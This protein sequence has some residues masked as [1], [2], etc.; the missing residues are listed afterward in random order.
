MSDL[1]G[2]VISAL[3]WRALSKL[4]AQLVSW[5]S[6]ILVMRQLLPDDYGLMAMGMVV[7][8]VSTL[9]AEMGMGATVVQAK[10]V[11]P[12]LLG[13]VAGLCI[14]SMTGLYLL[15]VL[16]SPLLQYLLSEP[17]LPGLL[18]IVALQLPLSALGVVPAATSERAMQYK[19]LS[20]IDLLAYSSAAL[21]TLL[22]AWAGWGVWALVCSQLSATGLRVLMLL[23]RFGWVRPKFDFRNHRGV[24]AFGGTL[25]IT[26]VIWSLS[27]QA[28]ILVGGKMVGAGA[29][30]I[31]TVAA[32]LANM[33]LQ[34]ISGIANQV[35][36]AALSRLQEKEENL[37]LAVMR[38][39]GNMAAVGAPLIWGIGAA[40]STLVPVL[41]GDKWIQAILPM[42]LICV[43]G[44]LRMVAS[45]LSSASIA[46]GTV[47]VDLRN[48][49]T[50]A[51]MMTPSFIVGAYF[52]GSTGIAL[53]W[54][55]VYPVVLVINTR[56]VCRAL[57]MSPWSI[58][59]AVKAPALAAL[60]SSGSV[61]LVARLAAVWPPA[62]VLAC[63]VLAGAAV[64]FALMSIW[65]PGF[66][67]D[68]RSFL[69]PGKKS[70]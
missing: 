16:A 8:N 48:T 54:A 4:L 62:V 34:K 70:G 51:V 59:S 32:D 18:A 57:N 41:L 44:P 22:A 31:Y 42:Q 27:S 61:L 56:R 53:A 5:S 24:L 64:Y 25:T 3:R 47:G 33:P 2:K 1:E 37:R 21:L 13:A 63:E 55:A 67:K 10:K 58:L 11:S 38:A 23:A 12:E 46:Q 40:S 30:G 66:L 36:F 43:A 20:L 35:V 69:G 65:M 6:T 68:I 29:L 49:A 7:L 50:T 39:V 26:R 14:A 60:A 15:I 52:G 19:A 45:M 28:D 9:I 17:R